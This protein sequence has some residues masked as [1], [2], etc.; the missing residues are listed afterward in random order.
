MFGLAD[1]NTSGEP[2][3]ETR[4]KVAAFLYEQLAEE[5]GLLSQLDQWTKNRITAEN[6]AKLELVFEA[7][8]PVEHCY[9]DLIREIDAEA[10]TGIYL[11]RSGSRKIALRRVAGESGVSGRL[12]QHLPQIA[13]QL[14]ADELEQAA[15]N[16][17]Q[18][19]VAIEARYDRAA[20]DA[21]I[22]KIIIG[23]LLGNESAAND[24]CFA[25]RS[26]LYTFHE[27]LARRQCELPSILNDRATQDLLTMI[28]ELSVRSGDYRDRIAAICRRAETE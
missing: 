9:Q 26:L 20:V 18:V 15:E 16:L 23:Q 24:M 21:C 19:W 2:L 12:Y 11:V 10:E 25:L 13:P 14:F 6:L 3:L 17:D 7:D 22:S 28:G 5:D 4:G 27:D 8:D 1:N